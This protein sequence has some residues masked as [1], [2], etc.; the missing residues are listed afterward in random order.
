[1]INYNVT[2]RTQTRIDN[3]V[4]KTW[5]SKYYYIS[6]YQQK[7]NVS[8]WER[9]WVKTD[10][11]FKLENGKEVNKEA[12]EEKAKDY[13]AKLEK[14]TVYEFL[15][16]NH[17]FEPDKSPAYL[18]SRSGSLSWKLNYA[19]S[20]KNAR[21]LQI[22]LEEVKDPIRD[23]VFEKVSRKDTHAF[24]ERLKNLETYV[25]G[26]KIQRKVTS[27]FRNNVLSAFRVTW[28]YYK[29][30]GVDADIEK[31][32]FRELK[33]FTDVDAKHKQKY[34]FSPEDYHDMFNR[35]L[36][37]SI[38]P[39]S[40]FKTKHNGS[41]KKVTKEQWDELV[42][43]SWIDFFELAFLTGARGGE[44]AALRVESFPRDYEGYVMVID[45]ALK[46]GLR[47][48]NV[49]N[50]TETVRVFD[51]TKTENERRI[52]LCDRAREITQ[53]YM[54]GKKPE[55]LLFTLPMKKKDNK[56]STLFVSQ[57]RAQAFSLFINELKAQI[58]FKYEDNEVFS[59]HG[60]RTSLNTQLLEAGNKEWVVAAA[61]GWESKALTRTQKKNYTKVELPDL[62][63]LAASINRIYFGKD[64]TWRPAD[65]KRA[66]IDR[67]E[68]VASILNASRKT[69]WINQVRGA[70]LE[71][72]QKYLSK[73]YD[74]F[75]EET[76]ETISQF[77]DVPVDELNKKNIDYFEP[78]LGQVIADD[79]VQYND[80]DQQLRELLGSYDEYNW[81]SP[82][83]FDDFEW[84]RSKTKKKK[85]ER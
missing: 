16:Q 52:V 18:D 30:T 42:N 22:I 69:R 27:T 47:K 19:Q 25:D 6:Y 85:R 34:I 64:F 78:I 32:P 71:I 15:K 61:L 36:L 39:I 37:S 29:E 35:E 24:R 68:R 63:Q 84:L 45:S 20:R 74:E 66:I 50:E 83:D 17:W 48:N 82:E 49:N 12:A 1:M 31:N 81:N 57:K 4:R 11:E 70:L 7:K 10:I 65:K 8:G 23:C 60:F 62:I 80:D 77:L 14:G 2:P 33:K 38:N 58:G 41:E 51:K 9:V 59:L 54:I 75:N 40:T 53:K 73:E 13:M 5:T 76:V 43:S 79:E 56:Y 67:Q 44:L 26:H 72:R 46:S 28:K 21:Y 55:D 3:G